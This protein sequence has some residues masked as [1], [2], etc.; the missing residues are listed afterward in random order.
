MLNLPRIAR[1]EQFGDAPGK[2][3]RTWQAIQFG[4]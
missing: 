3:A 2:T 4:D 1:H